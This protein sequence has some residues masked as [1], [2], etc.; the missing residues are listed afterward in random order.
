MLAG[1][2]DG[3]VADGDAAATCSV[4][5]V[6][7]LSV[8][9]YVGQP[10]NRRSVVSMQAITVGSDLSRIGSTTRNRHQASQAQYSVV[11]RSSM[12]GPSPKSY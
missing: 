11:A 12:T 5:T 7:S 6:F 10:P 3:G 4:V 2:D 8:S 1:S 9:L